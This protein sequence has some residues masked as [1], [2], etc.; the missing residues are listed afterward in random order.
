MLYNILLGLECEWLLAQ[1]VFATKRRNKK[2]RSIFVKVVAVYSG[3][4]ARGGKQKE[5]EISQ[6]NFSCFRL[7]SCKGLR[8]C[9]WRDQQQNNFANFSAR[10]K[11]KEKK[12]KKIFFD[13][14]H[15]RFPKPQRKTTCRF[16]F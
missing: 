4:R 12:K 11:A 16:D 15:T 13:L 5:D 9:A 1:V 10:K 3:P 6:N 14:S 8:A 7:N 2:S